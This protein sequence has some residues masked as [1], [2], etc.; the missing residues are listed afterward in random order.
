MKPLNMLE[1]PY[2]LTVAELKKIL[3]EWPEVDGNGEP[4]H[5]WISNEATG[6]S[7]TV[8]EVSPLNRRQSDDGTHVWADLFLGIE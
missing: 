6:V 5:V 4:T 1:F 2:G 3:A 7:N 8:S